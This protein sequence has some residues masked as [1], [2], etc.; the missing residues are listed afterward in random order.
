MSNSPGDWSLVCRR[1]S[2]PAWAMALSSGVIA[3]GKAAGSARWRFWPWVDP[4]LSRGVPSRDLGHSSWA[5]SRRSGCRSLSWGK[6][7]WGWPVA[8]LAPGGGSSRLGLQAAGL[9][10][11]GADVAWTVPLPGSGGTSFSPG[12][13]MRLDPM[14]SRGH[15]ITALRLRRLVR[16]KLSQCA[17]GARGQPCGRR[18]GHPATSPGG[19][20][21]LDLRG[22]QLSFLPRQP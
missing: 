14:V 13:G 1:V 3:R 12:P 2:K 22:A 4:I 19:L 5:A 17:G 10:R 6:G 7:A 8:A 16:R 21:A 18:G 11:R 15:G 9:D 20:P